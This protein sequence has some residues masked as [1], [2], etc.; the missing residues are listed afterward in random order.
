MANDKFKKFSSSHGVL[1]CESMERIVINL[2]LL[3]LKY[4]NLFQTKSG[5]ALTLLKRNY[6]LKMVTSNYRFYGTC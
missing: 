1:F 3:K 6:W 4:S 2:T 5:V